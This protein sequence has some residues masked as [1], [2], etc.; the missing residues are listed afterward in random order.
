MSRPTPPPTPNPGTRPLAQQA[1][2]GQPAGGTPP[3]TPPPSYPTQPPYGSGGGWNSEPPQYAAAPNNSSRTRTTVLLAVLAAVIA[4]IVIGGTVALSDRD[5]DSTTV[6]SETSTTPTTHTE[7]TEVTA[8]TTYS[9]PTYSTPTTSVAPVDGRWW[10]LAVS[11]D[12]DIVRF[13]KYD[14]EAALR[15]AGAEKY[16]IDDDWAVATFTTGCAAVASPT[17]RAD[18]DPYFVSRRTTRAAAR[19]AALEQSQSRT[20]KASQVHRDLCVGDTV[21]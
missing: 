17:V 9:T 14:T 19:D 5:D 16:D 18:D 2:Y 8:T 6:A 10:G 12:G 3:S 11:P 20:G 13:W 1:G 4:A 21:E 15:A 7:T